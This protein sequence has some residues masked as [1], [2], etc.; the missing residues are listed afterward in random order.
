MG[1][2]SRCV[3]QLVAADGRSIFHVLLPERALKAIVLDRV[4]THPVKDSFSWVLRCTAYSTFCPLQTPIAPQQ[5]CAP[6]ILHCRH[7]VY[8]PAHHTLHIS[9]CTVRTAR[10]APHILHHKA[11]TPCTIRT[12][13]FALCIPLST[14][15][16]PD[17]VLSDDRVLLVHEYPNAAPLGRAKP[18]D[19]HIAFACA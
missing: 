6:C 14:V 9:I 11:R 13:H 3:R 10:C 7:R 17:F 5:S 16:F 19:Q 8:Q 15:Q 12:T 2:W 4:Q 18:T 1:K